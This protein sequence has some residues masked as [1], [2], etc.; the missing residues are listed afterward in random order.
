MRW[1]K[2]RDQDEE[3]NKN[4]F[5]DK[6]YLGDESVLAV[7]DDET[8]FNLVVLGRCWSV[9]GFRLLQ[10]NRFEVFKFL[11]VHYSIRVGQHYYIKSMSLWSSQWCFIHQ[12]Q[13]CKKPYQ[14]SNFQNSN[15]KKKDDG[16][17]STQ[18]L[19]KVI[20]FWEKK[21]SV[22]VCSGIFQPN[23][24]VGCQVVQLHFAFKEKS[25]FLFLL[26][27]SAGKKGWNYPI[28]PAFWQKW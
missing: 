3:R 2:K 12:R 9:V 10:L 7:F 20:K 16:K 25:W 14:I 28:W 6:S 17:N 4:S 19:I 1:L 15:E 24:G 13:Y 18:K 21:T 22:G 27:F 5:R 23:L 8:R 11:F 26:V